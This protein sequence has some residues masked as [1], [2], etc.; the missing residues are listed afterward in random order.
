[1]QSNEAKKSRQPWKMQIL[2]SHASCHTH[3]GKR[4][5]RVSSDLSFTL[6][7][8]LHFYSYFVHKFKFY[9]LIHQTETFLFCFWLI[10]FGLPWW[11][12]LFR[13]CQQCGRPGFDLWVGKIPWRR[14]WLP[15]PVSLPG[16]FY[17][18]RGLAGYSPW[19]HKESNTTEWLS[20]H[21]TSFSLP[22]FVRIMKKEGFSVL[23]YHK[24]SEAN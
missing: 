24:L 17:G 23:S 7:M 8:H 14:E 22:N 2:S 20:L 10:F 4:R 19:G 1:M 18:Q 12:R 13:I 5:K 15:T 21:F 6:I 11:L 9:F 16:E 3:S